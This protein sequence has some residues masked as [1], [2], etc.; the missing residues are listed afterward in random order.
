MEVNLFDGAGKWVND[1]P[2][3]V[4]A[5]AAIGGGKEISVA[6]QTPVNRSIPANSYQ[7][8]GAL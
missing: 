1:R 8:V 6:M 5:L 2:V 3:M 4:K 7:Y